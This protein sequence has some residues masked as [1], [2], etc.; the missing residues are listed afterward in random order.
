VG[1]W[2]ALARPLRRTRPSLTWTAVPSCFDGLVMVSKDGRD[3]PI[4]TIRD[5][6]W[7]VNGTTEGPSITVAIPPVFEAYATFYE[8]DGV[9][10]AAHERAVA[11]RLVEFTPDQPWWLGYLDTGAHSVVFDDAP[12][13]S[14][15]WDWRYVLV[16]AGPEEAL[17]WRT[18]HMRAEYGVLPDL[19]FPEDRSWLVSALWDDTWT[20]IGGPETL[21]E[22]LHDDPQVQAWPVRLSVDA[23]PPGREREYATP[24]E[25]NPRM[26]QCHLGP[27]AWSAWTDT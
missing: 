3:W 20:C 16:A 13:V 12:R 8:P 5:V 10:I 9:S 11:K 23:K 15:Y 21:I 24:T 14:L 26:P 22:A 17:T 2:C 1:E 7:I 19:F 4:G 27:G 25:A 18:G 6:D